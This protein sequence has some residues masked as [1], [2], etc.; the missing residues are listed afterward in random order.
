MPGIKRLLTAGAVAIVVTA[1]PAL[2]EVRLPRLLSDGVVLQHGTPVSIWGWSDAGEPVSIRLDGECVGTAQPVNGRW[3]VVIDAVPAGGPHELAVAAENS[4]TVRDVYFGEVWVASGQSN[5][6]LAMERVSDKY[7]GEIAAAGDSLIRFFTVPRRYE[8]DAPL[9]DLDRGAWIPET[10]QSVLEFSAVAWFFAKEMREHA[11]VPVGIVS[12]SYGGSPAEGWMSEQALESFPHYLE[13]ARRYRDDEYLQQLQDADQA[14]ADAWYGNVDRLDRGLSGD[15]PWNEAAYD[16]S[17]WP[18]MILPGLWADGDLGP[19][20]GAV[21]FRRTFELPPSADGLSGRLM[22]GR[23]VDADTA[24]IN[25]IKI[26]ETSYQYPPRRYEVEAGILRAGENGIAVRVV[27]TAGEGGFVRD[28]PYELRVGATTV[29]LRGPWRYKVGAVSGPLPPP[30][31]LSYRQ[32]L[33]FYNAMLAPLVDMTIKGVIWY[34]GESNVLRA[35]EYKSLF[36]ALIRDWRRNWEQ[37]DFPFLFVQ[38]ANFLEP[39]ENPSESAWAELREAQLQ[40]LRVP[41]TAMAVTIDVGEWNDIHPL[42]KKAVGQRLALAARKIAYGESDL[43]ASGPLFRSLAVHGSRLIVGFNHAGSGLVAR[44]GGS[45]REFAIAGRDGRYVRARAKIDGDH[46]IVWSE[47]IPDPVS[48]RYAWADNPADANLY[49][50]EGLPASP[51]QA[52]VPGA[53]GVDGDR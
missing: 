2:A 17:E 24:W 48:V 23:I 19:V 4:V 40:A 22:L 49:N 18:R 12:S 10:P 15:L 32:P 41:N 21:W 30:R 5:M 11:G 52:G 26:G 36:P 34:Q 13:I 47:A 1:T 35:E 31:F 9:E 25:G 44:G 33:G 3:Q 14:A 6:E 20:N 45:L 38:L 46:V 27:N 29:D 28:K 7:P 39:A 16:A 43:V 42:N 53:G 50:R 8:F 51:F 37:G